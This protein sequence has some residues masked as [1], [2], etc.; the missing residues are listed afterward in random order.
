[1]QAATAVEAVV[2]NARGQQVR[3]LAA[4]TKVAGR[5][6]LYWD[7]RN[8]QGAAVAAGMYFLRTRLGDA[9]HTRKI[10]MQR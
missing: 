4:E 5:W 2:Y 3:T 10:V 1:L 8:D 9:L 6:R 7:G